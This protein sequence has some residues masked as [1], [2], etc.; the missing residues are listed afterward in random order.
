MHKVFPKYIEKKDPN[1]STL[2]QHPKY[3]KILIKKQCILVTSYLFIFL[4]ERFG[5]WFVGGLNATIG[6]Y[7]ILLIECNQATVIDCDCCVW[8]LV[9][10]C[11]RAYVV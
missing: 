11:V 9:V 5:F 2:T 1:S 8:T 7:F 10:G 3:I 6:P 4:M